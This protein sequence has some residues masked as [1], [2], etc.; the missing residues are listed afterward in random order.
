MLCY[1]KHHCFS[2][3]HQ[4]SRL[5][6]EGYQVSQTSF[7]LH[8]SMLTTPNHLLV[9]SIFGIPD[10]LHH[11]PKDPGEADWPIVPSITLLALLG[12]RSDICF[13]PDLRNAPHLP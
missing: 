12:Y 5:I 4:V 10:F 8:E 1:S 9:L 6:V 2:L 13:L 11:F 7:P 3:L